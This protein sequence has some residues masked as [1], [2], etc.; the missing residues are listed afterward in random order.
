MSAKG[1]SAWADVGSR[2]TDAER[3]WYVKA[4]VRW[5]EGAGAVEHKR[6]QNRIEEPKNGVEINLT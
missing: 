5:K 3:Q 1:E 4:D 6:E 2:L